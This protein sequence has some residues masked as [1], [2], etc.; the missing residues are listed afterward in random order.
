MDVSPNS[1]SQK[2]GLTLAFFLLKP[3]LPLTE[4]YHT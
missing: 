3:A 4:N 2:T 1:F